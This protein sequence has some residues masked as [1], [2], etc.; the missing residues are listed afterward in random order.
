M[1]ARLPKPGQRPVFGQHRLP[2][3]QAVCP[4]WPDLEALDIGR[5]VDY[6]RSIGA[7]QEVIDRF[8]WA[9]LSDPDDSDIEDDEP[10]PKG[11]RR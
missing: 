7:P 6:L 9:S 3:G 8:V 11:R 10:P 2:S 1:T 5:H 4:A